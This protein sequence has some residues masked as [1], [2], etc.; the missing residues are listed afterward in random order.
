MDIFGMQM[1]KRLQD[2]K[3]D[4]YCRGGFGSLINNYV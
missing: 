1:N 2:F 4:F 3:Q